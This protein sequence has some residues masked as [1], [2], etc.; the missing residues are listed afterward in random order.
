MDSSSGHR[1]IE[2][3]SPEDLTFLVQ[4][5]RRVA[6]THLDEAFPP[7]QGGA[8]GERD[9]MREQIEELVNQVCSR[10]GVW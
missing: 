1:R 9:E 4:N 5:V 10:A 3:Q 7:I 6:A 8:E 2:L